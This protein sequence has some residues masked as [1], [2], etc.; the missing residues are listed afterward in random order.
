MNA[1]FI[2][3]ISNLS[4]SLHPVQVLISGFGY[5]IGITLFMIAIGKLRKIGD[6]R[7]S[8]GGH[9]KMFVPLAYFLGGSAL[10]FLPSALTVLINT[11]FGSSSILGYSEFNPYNIYDAMKIV[12]QTAGLLWFVRGTI[13]LVHSSEAGVQDGP[14]GLTFLLAGILAMNFEGT[15]GFLNYVLNYLMNIGSTTGTKPGA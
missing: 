6:A 15:I 13:L 14:K 9:E 10:I 4:Q 2:T 8:G 12:M 3:M 5:L 11:A 7:A 1:T